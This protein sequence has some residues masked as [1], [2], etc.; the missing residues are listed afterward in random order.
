MAAVTDKT[1]EVVEKFLRQ[2]KNAD[3]NIERAVLFGSYVRGQAG[4]GVISLFNQYCSARM[5]F[6]PG[7][8]D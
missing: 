2:L 1:I 6:C 8:G 3:I 5:I 4:A 7:S